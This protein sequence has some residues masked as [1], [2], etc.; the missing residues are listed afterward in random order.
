MARQRN[1]FRWRADDDPTLN[2]GL[3]V[4]SFSG[5]RTSIAKK[6]YIFMIFQGG[7]KPPV[8][9]LWIRQCICWLCTLTYQGLGLVP[10]LWAVT[11][12]DNMAVFL[13]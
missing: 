9:L 13:V 2:A 6:P 1:V 8:T 3:V 5:L 7:S 11:L 4:F 12:F 10:I